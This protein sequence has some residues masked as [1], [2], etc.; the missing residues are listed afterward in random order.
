MDKM[1]KKQLLDIL[2]KPPEE[3]IGYFQ[4][5]GYKISWNWEDTWQECHAKAFTAAKCMELDILQDIRNEVK[6]AMESGE[7]FRRFKY[8]LKPILASKGWWGRK[9]VKN[10]DG[11]DEEVQ[12]G[13]VRRLRIIYETNLTTSYRA[14]QYKTQWEDRANRPYWMYVC[15]MLPTSRESHRALHG[16][17]FRAD[18]PFWESFY[19]PNGWGCKCD[20]VALTEEELGSMKYYTPVPKLDEKGRQIIRNGIPEYERAATTPEI[21]SSQGCLSQTDGVTGRS[22]HNQKV[23][24]YTDPKTGETTSPDLGWDHNVGKATYR[25]PDLSRYDD[26]LVA[27]YLKA[28]E[29]FKKNISKTRLKNSLTDKNILVNIKE[30]AQTVNEINSKISN[31]S[32]QK[33]KTAKDN[34]Y[35]VAD[36]RIK[37]SKINKQE[38][39]KFDNE[40]S[41]AELLADNGHTVYLVAEDNPAFAKNYDAI[42]DMHKVDF[43]HITGGLKAITRNF[44]T[45][46]KQ[47]GNVFMSIAEDF[48]IQEIF[49][50]IY[51]EFL[52]LDK[53]DECIAVLYFPKTGVFAYLYLIK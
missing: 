38:K 41:I 8:N 4:A 18:D 6:N 32:Y 40:K 23:S 48:D 52:S 47:A 44:R 25:K 16:K 37:R 50:K 39:I 53:T 5:K 49:N 30:T 3:I 10:P 29:A 45:G 51:G 21:C 36:E 15:K 24:Q 46:I 9:T 27:E 35:F 1:N 43:K 33:N 42:V 22:G 14:G 34:E 28:E 17:V 31:Y 13:S 2:G 20:V 12:L 11:E 19:P 7:T 26:D